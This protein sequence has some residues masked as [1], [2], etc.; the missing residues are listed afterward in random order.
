MNEEKMS[1]EAKFNIIIISIFAIITAFG[2]F[3]VYKVA[4]SNYFKYGATDLLYCNGTPN[5]TPTKIHN[6]QFSCDKGVIFKY[7][8]G[9]YCY[10]VIESECGIIPPPVSK[11]MIKLKPDPKWIIEASKD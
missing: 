6:Y 8:N 3:S 7:S 11:G 2:A 4:S 10:R 9:V 1:K 5:G